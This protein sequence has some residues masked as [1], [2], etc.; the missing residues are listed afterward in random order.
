MKT[1]EQ[2]KNMI[3]Q[4]PNFPKSGVNFL[5]ITPILAD[6]N[7]LQS[8]VFC[9]GEKINWTNIDVVVGIESRGFILAAALATKYNKGLTLCRKAGKLPP[10]THRASYALEYGEATIEMAPGHGRALIVDDVLA[11]GGTL[12]AA[13]QITE[14][15][16]YHVHDLLVM[17]DIQFLNQMKFKGQSVKSLFQF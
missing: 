8:L 6:A 16:G 14:K 10:P 4:V 2:L 11:T 9:M 5:D 1:P 17:I 12:Q 13:I 3:R 15:A 7:S